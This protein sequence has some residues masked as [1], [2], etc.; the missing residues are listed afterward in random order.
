MMRY[1]LMVTY[2]FIFIFL[3]N[4]VNRNT[5]TN[6]N[7]TDANVNP[8]TVTQV[9]TMSKEA[10]E[11][12]KQRIAQREVERA[13]AA[14]KSSSSSTYIALK[15]GKRFKGIFTG[16]VDEQMVDF[17]KDGTTQA[18]KRYNYEVLL[19]EDVNGNKVQANNPTTFSAS[20]TTSQVIDNLLNNGFQKLQIA[21]GGSGITDTQYIVT[22]LP[23]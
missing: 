7:S 5:N 13:A 14:A 21:R 11:K 23:N 3:Y 9:A 17:S 18:V 4:M 12:L 20:K 19:L 6:T 2:V 22:P 8:I 10:R 16:N 1:Y 15:D